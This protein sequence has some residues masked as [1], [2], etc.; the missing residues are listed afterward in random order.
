M[1]IKWNPARNLRTWGLAACTSVLSLKKNQA[2]PKYVFLVR[3]E[4]IHHVSREKSL[5]L[6]F[7]QPS[8][9]ILNLIYK[10]WKKIRQEIRTMNITSCTTNGIGNCT[11]AF[12][13]TRKSCWGRLIPLIYWASNSIFLSLWPFS[14]TFLHIQRY[15]AQIMSFFSQNLVFS[16][17][18]M[19]TPPPLCSVIRTVLHRSSKLLF[20]RKSPKLRAKNCLSEPVKGSQKWLWECWQNFGRTGFSSFVVALYSHFTQTISVLTLCMYLPLFIP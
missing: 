16:L 5:L 14:P 7:Q 11:H 12:R 4:I 6:A 20:C 13:Y 17:W 10:K 3:N 9:S 1:N 15:R 18:K 2:A 8:T 19:C